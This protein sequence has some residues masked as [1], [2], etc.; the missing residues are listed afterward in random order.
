MAARRAGLRRPEFPPAGGDQRRANTVVVAAARPAGWPRT[1]VPCCRTMRSTQTTSHLPVPHV[2]SL[3]SPLPTHP[4]P[5]TQPNTQPQPP[6]LNKKGCWG[7]DLR[8]L[9]LYYIGPIRLVDRACPQTTGNRGPAGSGK[10]RPPPRPGHFQKTHNPAGDS[11]PPHP[12][13]PIA[14][15]PT[16]QDG[17]GVSHQLA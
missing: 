14:L 10:R 15:G 5:R 6:A 11:P 3:A 2:P 1:R 4:P 16:T 12:F 7:K 13:N 17:K 8:P 9:I